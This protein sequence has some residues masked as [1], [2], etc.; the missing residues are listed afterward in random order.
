MVCRRI[1]DNS[2]GS[3]TQAR[4]NEPGFLLRC[5]KPVKLC[6]RSANDRAIP[7]RR[8]DAMSTDSLN[9]ADPA[10]QNAAH[11]N[12]FWSRLQRALGPAL[13]GLLLDLADLCSLTN[14][15][16]PFAS[17]PIGLAIGI[18]LSSYYP[19]GFG[20]RCAIAVASG[21]YTLTPGTEYIPLATIMT[22]LGR[23]VEAAPPNSAAEPAASVVSPN[24]DS[25]VDHRS[26]QRAA[27]SS[28]AC[29]ECGS[30]SLRYGEVAQRFVPSGS[31][32]WA[33][34]HEINAFVCLDCGFVGH[35]LASGDLD[36]LRE[37]SQ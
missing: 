1:A 21:L 3:I 16:G 37:S 22:C 19:F 35:Y 10:P 5:R 9:P 23:F 25:P 17:F 11:K 36:Q 26:P 27:P 4:V 8:S 29:P 28:A 7:R 33:K 18:W 2:S 14:R 12:S 30:H 32:V 24:G 34:G 15:V 31:S 13:P 6:H 20:W